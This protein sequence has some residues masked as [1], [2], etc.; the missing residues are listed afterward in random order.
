MKIEKSS[1]TIHL[2]HDNIAVVQWRDSIDI[3]EKADLVELTESLMEVGGGAKVPVLVTTND[4]LY[5]TEEAKSYSVS[6]EAQTYTLANAVLI[7]SLGKKLV[8]NMYLRLFKPP[9]PTKAFQSKRLAIK[10]L[11]EMYKKEFGG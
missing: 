5:L 7:D 4:F 8:F 2:E 6:P 9:L 3:I 1:H 11:M 10:W